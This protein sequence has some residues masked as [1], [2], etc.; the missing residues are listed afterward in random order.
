MKLFRG[1]GE[2]WSI[3]LRLEQLHNVP[4]SVSLAR[5]VVLKDK[6]SASTGLVRAVASGSGSSSSLAPSASG[7][8]ARMG[9]FRLLIRETVTLPATMF[10]T[11]KQPG[12]Y[13][14]KVFD[15]QL[16]A[17]VKDSDPEGAFKPVG[18]AQLDVAPYC[19]MTE[20]R[21]AV[22]ATLQMR[23]YSSSGVEIM[24]PLS[25]TIE[26]ARVS[27]ASAAATPRTSVTTAGSA[28]TAASAS[29]MG[30]GGRG[31][32]PKRSLDVPRARPPLLLAAAP[33]PTIVTAAKGVR[34]AERKAQEQE[35]ASRAQQ[36]A[37]DIA[38][39]SS[40]RAPPPSSSAT[41]PEE[42]TPV[43][44]LRKGPSQRSGS[45]M[46]ASRGEASEFEAPP[47]TTKAHAKGGSAG[48]SIELTRERAETLP[49]VSATFVLGE[50]TPILT[51]SPTDRPPADATA[52]PKKKGSRREASAQRLRSAR[53]CGSASN[54]I[55]SDAPVV[56]NPFETPDDVGLG[57][58]AAAPPAS[59]A[60]A[61]QISPLE[62]RAAAMKV[63]L[64]GSS[65]KKGAA[66]V[67][68][69]M[70]AEAAS[71]RE[72]RERE[73]RFA[74]LQPSDTPPG[75]ALAQAIS[76]GQ[77]SS[78]LSQQTSEPVQT[79]QAPSPPAP[80]ESKS[81]RFP[82]LFS[83]RR[84]DRSPSSGSPAVTA[85][86]A[87]IMVSP[88]PPDSASAQPRTVIESASQGT[89][90][91]QYASA[92]SEFPTSTPPGGWTATS[93]SKSDV[94]QPRG[95]PPAPGPPP[96]V[97][98]EGVAVFEAQSE[99]IAELTSRVRDLEASL[100]TERQQAASLQGE[101]LELRAA[102]RSMDALT[103]T[104][105]DLLRRIRDL[106]ELRTDLRD[107]LERA[108]ADLTTAQTEVTRATAARAELAD[109]HAEALEELEDARIHRASHDELLAA[110]RAELQ[111]AT[112][113]SA[114]YVTEQEELVRV[115]EEMEAD[116]R[117]LVAEEKS[118]AAERAKL[119]VRE[120]ELQAK[121]A[122]LE[123]SLED[124]L[125]KGHTLEECLGKEKEKRAGHER[126][127][128]KAIEAAATAARNLSTLQEENAGLKRVI[129]GQEARTAA[130][131]A[132]QREMAVLKGELEEALREAEQGFKGLE[133]EAQ[134]FEQERRTMDDRMNATER[135]LAEAE[136]RLA[137]EIE[138]SEGLGR[139]VLQR[140]REMQEA[141]EAAEALERT[142]AENERK[143]E[144]ALARAAALE[145]AE[146]QL[147]RMQ[148]VEAQA[149]ASQADLTA[150]VAEV[151][152]LRRQ[153]DAQDQAYLGLVR[154]LEASQTDGALQQAR[155]QELEGRLEGAD[156][157][158][159]TVSSVL[160]LCTQYHIP[161]A[162]FECDEQQKVFYIRILI[163]L[164]RV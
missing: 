154:Q 105:E 5:L 112:D 88:G 148:S 82:G 4:S 55:S 130:L 31:T 92:A 73:Q 67:G 90:S 102:A 68:E 37:Q 56:D 43:P 80:K 138:R 24:S 128:R 79:P 27:D 144:T 25:L 101:V 119:H 17:P 21:R 71:G 48:A 109:R 2:N 6:R 54:V 52:P 99:R 86:P 7:A 44:A 133:A 32:G 76:L 12:Q 62:A 15:I 141:L 66:R 72:A 160:Q 84:R 18:H 13:D 91:D 34:A 81:M 28:R 110:M 142:C 58:A 50:A 39:P 33:Q 156:V 114:R 14:P 59:A 115:V 53:D 113:E 131:E 150:A 134:W 65:R 63:A 163:Q 147:V 108:E 74:T 85:A 111:H 36:Q 87:T 124:S 139:Q 61:P 47:A 94:T 8:S 157:Q 104:Q 57:L 46:R 103:E 69:E 16:Q 137:L 159:R 35:S 135:R 38:G 117:R 23:T 107:K 100:N 146:A 9:G 1:K 123:A 83:L 22:P 153:A 11:G 155:V 152:E 161:R 116:Y 132:E 125:A 140:E 19:A 49:R 98:S 118:W 3:S 136:G 41:P 78:Q 151:A 60:P 149:A 10:P 89:P 70:A 122:A 75:P 162:S 127:A 20:P 164:L 120:E 64:R 51:A 121:L 129:E 40:S 26:C 96:A 145:A 77:S 126:D 42:I 158:L 29:G 97:V 45:R 95:Q 143:L 106:E 93:A 30:L